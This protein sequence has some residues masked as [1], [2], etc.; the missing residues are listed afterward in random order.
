VDSLLRGARLAIGV[1]IALIVLALPAT[2]LGQ[3]TR[4]ASTSGSG[5][6]CTEM[7]PCSLDTAVEDPSVT[8]GDEVIVAPGTYTDLASDSL[9]VDDS[10]NLHGENGAPRPVVSETATA[11][12]L[13][14]PQ[15]FTLHDMEFF[16]AGDGAAV[17]LGGPATIYDVSN[18][19]ATSAITNGFTCNLGGNLTMRDSICRNISGSATGAA[20]GESIGTGTTDSIT[21]RNTTLYS[22]NGPGVS[23]TV[24]GTGSASWD[25]KNVIA[26]SG[27]GTDVRATESDLTATAS[28]ALSHS[29]YDTRSEITGGSVTDPA[30]N[31]NQTAAPQFVDAPNGDFHQLATS[32]T[33]NAGVDDMLGSSDL[34]GH[35]RTTEGVPDIGA[36]EFF[37]DADGDGV[38]DASD[39]CPVNANADQADN[40]GDG[41]GNACD[42][43]PN[44]PPPPDG[45]G[46]DT[47]PPDTTITGG[48]KDKTK[49]KQATFEF[50]SSEPGSSFQC[51]VDGQALKVPCTS[52]YTVKVNKGKHT[53]EVRATDAAG[54]ADASPATD[55]WKVKKPK[56]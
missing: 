28:V 35:P 18:I 38:D 13:F 14:G 10:I 5:T 32:P 43:T 36:D 17:V 23:V 19:I 37:P 7:N 56:K 26:F 48:P 27:G 4:Y 21:M 2:S 49:K 6:A 41:V 45:D 44:G 3:T 54:N 33:R 25:L 11:T 15:G 50:A 1:A 30:T 51:G 24:G 22:N 29:N 8:S 12:T 42:P 47:T 52:P 46:A 53:F 9:V 40:D 16:N 55:S 20:A 39:N 34:D 31:N